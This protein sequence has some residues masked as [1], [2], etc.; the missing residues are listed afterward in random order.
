MVFIH[1]VY[2]YC[3]TGC[4]KMQEFKGYKLSLNEEQ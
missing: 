3:N 1:I 4:T 2:L